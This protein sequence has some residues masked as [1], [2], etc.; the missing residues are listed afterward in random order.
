MEK[1]TTELVLGLMS[2][3]KGNDREGFNAYFNTLRRQDLELLQLYG[4][5][6]ADSCD[7][8]L[9]QRQERQGMAVKGSESKVTDEQEEYDLNEWL[10]ARTEKD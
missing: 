5:T 6:L 1:T 8:L 10:T 9:K 4:T 7:V 3:K 2:Y